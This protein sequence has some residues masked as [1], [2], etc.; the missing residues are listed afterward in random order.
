MVVSIKKSGWKISVLIALACQASA[1]GRQETNS[2]KLIPTLP[3]ARSVPLGLRDG[4]EEYSAEMLQRFFKKEIALYQVAID[5][6]AK[7]PVLREEPLMNWQNPERMANQGSFFIWLDEGRPAMV[8]SIFTYVYNG[9]TQRRH[10]LISF[11]DKPMQVSFDGDSVWKPKAAET[12]G[13]VITDVGEPATSAPRRLTQMRAIA[14]ELNGRLLIQPPSILR[15]ISTPLLRYESETNGVIDGAIFSL[16]V[17][18]DP[19][20]LVAIEA[21]KGKQG[22]Q[23]YVTPFRSHYS[24]LDLEY[25][26]KALWKAEDKPELMMT[27]PLQ[28]PFAGESF[29]VF[30]PKKRLPP[31]ESLK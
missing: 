17:V 6:Q 13:W 3:P 14:R 23:W 15:L 5:G 2:P 24:G 22:M 19:E 21:R 18:T 9:V 28:M 20:I 30:T 4:K 1:F 25:R 29:F 10:E 12:A 8:A 31:A 7:P 11:C 26:G 27:G 16:A